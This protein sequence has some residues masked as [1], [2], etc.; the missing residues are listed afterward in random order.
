MNKLFSLFILWSLIT[1]ISTTSYARECKKIFEKYQ[2]EPE[3]KSS[4][5]W[6]RVIRQ[7]N[8]NDYITMEIDEVDDIFLK[9]CLIQ[10]GFKIEHY[11]RSIGGKI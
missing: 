10:Y 6:K 8:L 2:I 7:N 1:G 9:K 3:I 5:G 11:K 4:R